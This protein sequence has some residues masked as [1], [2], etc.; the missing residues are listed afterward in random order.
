[1][2]ISEVWGADSAEAAEEAVLCALTSSAAAC[3]SSL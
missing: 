2:A 1:M 3:P